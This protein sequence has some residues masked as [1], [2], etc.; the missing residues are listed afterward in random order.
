MP[1]T[2]TVLTFSCAPTHSPRW[3]LPDQC[4]CQP[5]SDPEPWSEGG[6]GPPRRSD[7][8]GP[9]RAE[10]VG[11]QTQ[12]GSQEPPGE[13]TEPGK[14][15]FQS[16]NVILWIPFHISSCHKAIY[17]YISNTCFDISQWDCLSGSHLLDVCPLVILATATLSTTRSL[18]SYW[19][20]LRRIA[21]LTLPNIGRSAS[22]DCVEYWL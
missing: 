12:P 9:G 19:T 10:G 15:L 3:L 21:R 11:P 17:S 13:T 5:L 18:S 4:L 14:T 16:I 7:P 20:V 22:V 2:V 6:P 8:R 1:F